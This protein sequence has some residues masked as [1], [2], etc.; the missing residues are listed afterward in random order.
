M[1]VAR[2]I[3]ADSAEPVGAPMHEGGSRAPLSRKSIP[4]PDAAVPAA[5]RTL[6][7]VDALSNS[8]NTPSMSRWSKHRFRARAEVCKTLKFCK[9]AWTQVFQWL[10]HCGY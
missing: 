5:V 2:G 6:G 1:R 7:P 9:K 3:G 10:W 8:A 4:E